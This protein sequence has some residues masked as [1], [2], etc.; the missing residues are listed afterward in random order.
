LEHSREH[1]EAW[2]TA[3]TVVAL[4][5]SLVT[6]LVGGWL[7]LSPWALGEWAS[8]GDWTAAGRTEFFSGLGLVALAVVCVVPVTVQVVGALRVRPARADSPKR[9]GDDSPELES[10]L[11]AVAHA[12][13][14]DLVS[15]GSGQAGDP[16]N[17][18]PE[19]AP[20]PSDSRS[21]DGRKD[22]R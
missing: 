8:N 4:S 16:D 1:D 12:L 2:V 13:A 17:E 10:T 7:M 19:R 3:R 9:R 6:G 15:R 22:E 21:N 11:V 14:A 20:H 5:W 18:A